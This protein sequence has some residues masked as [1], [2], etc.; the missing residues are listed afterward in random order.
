MR[1]AIFRDV[2]AALTTS[3]RMQSLSPIDAGATRRALVTVATRHNASSRMQGDYVRNLIG[4]PSRITD[5]TGL[6]K[7]EIRGECALVRKHAAEWLDAAHA[8]AIFARFAQTQA[9][10]EAGING[11]ATHMQI[12]G[13]CG[14]ANPLGDAERTAAIR[15][16]V[17]RR[18]EPQSYRNG[19]SLR[20]I[21]KRTGLSRPTL[22]RIANRI[23]READLLEAEG[24]AELERKFVSQGI[25]A[26][27]ND[28]AR[29]SSFVIRLNT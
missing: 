10:K 29:A 2:M 17:S 18:Y 15:E 22:A 12:R 20:D 3:F 28:R 1:G 24:L 25:C 21:E 6:S 19:R 11:L 27:S 9:E 8:S 5:F 26:L 7:L 23:E 14:R 13:L 16:L 4:A